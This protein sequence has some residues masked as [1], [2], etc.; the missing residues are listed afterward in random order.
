VALCKLGVNQLRKLAVLLVALALVLSACGGDE[1]IAGVGDA[2]IRL[3]DIEALFD[4]GV[5]SDDVFR[6][7]LF[8]KM[9]LEALGQAL[10]GQYGTAV[11][12]T[13]AEE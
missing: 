1:D 9:A 6:D 3:S 13:Q 8:S 10:A 12:E 7:M 5:P 11:D 2:V 4:G